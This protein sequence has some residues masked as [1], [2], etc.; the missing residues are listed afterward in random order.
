VQDRV[1]IIKTSNRKRPNTSRSHSSRPNNRRSNNRNSSPSN[2]RPNSN[3]FEN[4]RPRDEYGNHQI[5]SEESTERKVKVRHKRKILP[6]GVKK[7]DE[8]PVF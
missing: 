3:R 2:N 5:A 6:R 1:A 4:S 7:D 8:S